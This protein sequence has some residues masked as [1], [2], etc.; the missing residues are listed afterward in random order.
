MD[1]MAY[2]DIY[3]ERTAPG[4]L[5]EPLNFFSNLAFIFAGLLILR[6]LRQEPLRD[7][8]WQGLSLLAASMMIVV[9][10]G[11]MLFHSFATI[12][13]EFADVIPI[14][15]F[16]F[17]F[18][19]LH[20]LAVVNR[21]WLGVG[22]AMTG[23][24][25][26]GVVFAQVIDPTMVNGSQDYFAPLLLLMVLSVIH[27]RKHAQSGIWMVAGCATFVTSLLM[28]GMDLKVCEAWP[29][30][31]HFLWHTLNGVLLYALMRGLIGFL[32]VQESKARG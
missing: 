22:I 12:W 2:T 28:R 4:L 30:G 3:C 16:V 8:K 25:I 21:G 7:N 14:A 29:F 5:N 19:I 23:L 27:Y 24:V 31:T 13:A 11:S 10:I 32:R 15:I 9:G 6:M 1:L 17:Y 26:A 18:L 20:V